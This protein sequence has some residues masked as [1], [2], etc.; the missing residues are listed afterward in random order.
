MRE[1][2]I[3]KT[4]GEGGGVRGEG[5]FLNE[6]ISGFVWRSKGEV[7]KRC[8]RL[9]RKNVVVRTD[10]SHRNRRLNCIIINFLN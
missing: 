10:S 3:D 2:S 7:I 6:Q 4:K 9:K 8:E 1:K 5:V